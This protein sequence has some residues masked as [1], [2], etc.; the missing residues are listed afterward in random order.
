MLASSCV[1]PSRPGRSAPGTEVLLKRASVTQSWTDGANP[2][3]GS[4]A[5]TF[6]PSP[7][8]QLLGAIL[9]GLALRGSTPTVA[10]VAMILSQPVHILAFALNMFDPAAL[11]WD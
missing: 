8:G 5:R 6:H 2:S 9:M 4:R 11:A 3:S 1:K 7:V 10:W